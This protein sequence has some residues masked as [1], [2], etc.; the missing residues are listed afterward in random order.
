MILS[1]KRGRWKRKEKK[2]EEEEK[3]KEEEEKERK[4]NSERGEAA[5][6]LLTGKR[7]SFKKERGENKEKKG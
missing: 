1:T 4:R 2:R 6:V 3:E 5:S 7:R